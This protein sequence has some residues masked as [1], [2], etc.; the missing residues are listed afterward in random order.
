LRDVIGELRQPVL[1]VH[2]ARD[3]LAPV[4]ASAWMAACLPDVQVQIMDKA[5]HAPFI[6]HPSDFVSAMQGFLERH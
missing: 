3:T 2:G 5:A 6:S 1:L 4:A